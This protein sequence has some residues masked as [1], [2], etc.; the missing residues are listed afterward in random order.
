MDKPSTF[1]EVLLKQCNEAFWGKISATLHKEDIRK[2]QRFTLD[3]DFV[4]HIIKKCY[5]ITA[6]EFLSCIARTVLPY[7]TIWLEF[8]GSTLAQEI[9]RLDE[10]A[11]RDADHLEKVGVFIEIYP[12]A[13]PAW[14]AYHFASLP[15]ATDKVLNGYKMPIVYAVDP[16]GKIAQ[17]EA[18]HD[19]MRREFEGVE[20]EKRRSTQD[21]SLMMTCGFRK[22]VP[23]LRDYIEILRDAYF[24]EALERRPE[25][26]E[27]VDA[28][29]D[30]NAGLLRFLVVTLAMINEPRQ[31]EKTLIPGKGRTYFHGE[32]FRPRPSTTIVTL[33]PETPITR[34]EYEQPATLRN[35]EPVVRREHDVRS[36]LRTIR[37]GDVLTCQHEG[38]T[39][40]DA[41]HLWCPNCNLLRTTV[42]SHR[43]GSKAKG[44]VEHEY[45]VRGSDDGEHVDAKPRR[46][47]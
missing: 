29:L 27:M 12:D 21:Y 28:D 5:A 14:R 35:A 7:D 40:L 19:L 47:G 22:M 26:L 8:N 1:A 25:I 39:W 23:E 33:R 38:F 24:T 36:H 46:V 31:I 44:R 6:A 2:A 16:E 17:K 37:R 41:K 43:R 4:R 30:G 10:E 18:V 42:P 45:I 13:R 3:D 9:L 34:L 32:G 11:P 20:A 15:N